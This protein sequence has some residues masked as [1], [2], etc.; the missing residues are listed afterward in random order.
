MLA[1]NILY[2]FIAPFL[3]SVAVPGL[4]DVVLLVF[5]SGPGSRPLHVPQA[6]IAALA[7]GTW[8][9]DRESIAFA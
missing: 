3:A 5:W 9:D 6:T 2:T 1:H 4:P 8:I 7:E